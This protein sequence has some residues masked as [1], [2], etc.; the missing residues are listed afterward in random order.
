MS[1]QVTPMVEVHRQLPIPT[2]EGQVGPIRGS[3]YNE[4]Y[5]QNVVPSKQVLADEGSYF[6][7]TNPTP[8]TAVT[9]ATI[10]GATSYV[11]TVAFCVFKNNDNAG[12]PKAKRTYLDTI[13]LILM[14]TAPATTTVMHYAVVLDNAI[15]IP[16]AGSVSVTGQNVNMDDNNTPVT[17]LWTYSAGVAT[18]PAASGSARIVGRGSVQTSLGITGDEYVIQFGAQ[19]Q[20]GAQSGLTAVRAAAAAKMT[21]CTAPVVL[22]PQQFC[23]IHLWWLTVTTTAPGFEYEFAW[24]ER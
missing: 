12:N 17:Q 23:V 1:T 11:N 5:V 20:H 22:G 3:R 6:V 24:W 18:V 7:G 16:T 15:R 9:F 14:G 21:S 13:R 10:A 19:D 8:G 4:I 2:V